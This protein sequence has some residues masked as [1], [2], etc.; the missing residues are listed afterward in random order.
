EDKTIDLANKYGIVISEDFIYSERYSDVNIFA[1]RY[2]GF[3]GRIAAVPF[4]TPF[5]RWYYKWKTYSKINP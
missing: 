3:G 1:H 2:M 5:F 4:T